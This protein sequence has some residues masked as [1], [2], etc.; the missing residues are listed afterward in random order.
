MNR[1]PPRHASFHSFSSSQQGNGTND[2]VCASDLSCHVA[3]SSRQPPWRQGG[4]PCRAPGGL[5]RGQGP[6]L[7]DSPHG[8]QEELLTCRHWMSQHLL[9]SFHFQPES[10][11]DSRVYDCGRL[12]GIS[13]TLWGPR[14]KDTRICTY[15]WFLNFAAPVSCQ[16]LVNDTELRAGPAAPMKAPLV[17]PRVHTLR[18]RTV[19]HLLHAL[20]SGSDLGS[21][22]HMLPSVC[23]GQF[24]AHLEACV[25]GSSNTRLCAAGKRFCSHDSGP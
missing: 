18:R 7:D 17:P 5:L 6:G 4:D 22:G 24:C 2:T 25:C 20:G 1:S 8:S 13:W 12:T 10:A 11:R 14:A 3:E 21:T 23:H 19:S 15:L 16:D 9:T